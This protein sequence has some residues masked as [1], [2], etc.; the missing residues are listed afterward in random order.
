LI[1]QVVE[2]ANFTFGQNE[3]RQKK[4]VYVGVDDSKLKVWNF[5]TMLF[6]FI[7]KIYLFI[8]YEK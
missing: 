3:E 1:P 5:F 2:F 8:L 6:N 4:L 7:L